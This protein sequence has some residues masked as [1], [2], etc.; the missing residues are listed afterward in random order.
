M[1]NVPVGATL[2]RRYYQVAIWHGYGDT[3]DEQRDATRSALIEWARHDT[4]MP[5]QPPTVIERWV[6]TEPRTAGSSRPA[7][8]DIEVAR[9]VIG[10]TDNA[11]GNEQRRAAA[12]QIL[13]TIDLLAA[14]EAAEQAGPG[15]TARLL[16]PRCAAPNRGLGAHVFLDDPRCTDWTGRCGYEFDHAVHAEGARNLRLHNEDLARGQ[17]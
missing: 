14:G 16:P 4:D 11:V 2:T 13:R 1:S 15:V 7:T 10:G 9:R 17:R 6:M 5:I 8:W 3:F 12:D